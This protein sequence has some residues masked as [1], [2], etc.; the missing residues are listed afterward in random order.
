MNKLLR[1][2]AFEGTVMRNP[3]GSW[4]K[5]SQEELDKMLASGKAQK[6]N[7]KDVFTGP[8][9]RPYIGLVIKTNFGSWGVIIDVFKRNEDYLFDLFLSSGEIEKNLSW[10]RDYKTAFGDRLYGFS[11]FGDDNYKPNKRHS[12]EIMPLINKAEDALGIDMQTA[13]EEDLY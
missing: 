1:F 11:A 13:K 3:D 10:N 12:E 4:K 6:L 2:K 8:V 7:L 9:K 5:I